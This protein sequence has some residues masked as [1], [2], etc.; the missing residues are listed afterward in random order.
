MNRD[1][2]TSWV[3]PTPLESRKMD[4]MGLRISGAF[5]SLGTFPSHTFARFPLN[6][7]VSAPRRLSARHFEMLL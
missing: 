6:F 7:Q 2:R 3:L 1:R 5:P 4:R